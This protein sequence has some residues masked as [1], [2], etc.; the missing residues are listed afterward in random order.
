MNKVIG[1]FKPIHNTIWYEVREVYVNEEG[2][3]DT[4]TLKVNDYKDVLDSLPIFTS[5]SYCP[6]GRSYYR[7][8]ENYQFEYTHSDTQ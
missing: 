2:K 1:I 3:I 8:F 5:M 6:D 7:Q 4:K